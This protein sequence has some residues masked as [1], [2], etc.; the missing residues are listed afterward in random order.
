MPGNYI[1]NQMSEIINSLN[2]GRVQVMML[3]GSNMMS[4]FADAEH[5]ATGLARTDLVVSYDL[6][7]NDT[8]RRFADVFLPGTAWLEQ[9]GYAT[10]G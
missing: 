5:M 9:L 10:S 7:M 6:F 2:D 8:T 3:F 4:S 1:P